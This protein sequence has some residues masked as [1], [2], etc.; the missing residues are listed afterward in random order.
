MSR[1][2]YGLRPVEE[3]LRSKR[4]IAVVYLLEGDRS[5]AL[6]AIAAEARAANLTVMPR[7]RAALD[8]LVGGK[9]HQGAVAVAGDFPYLEPLDVVSRATEKLEVPLLLVLDG[10]QDPQNLGALVR[11]AHVLG[12]HGVIMPKDRAVQ[13]TPAVVKASAGATEHTPIA[14]CANL[15]RTLEELKGAGVWTVG[16]L[17]D[18]GEDPWRLDLTVPIALVLGAEGT[19]LRPL[20]VRGC[21]LL[22]KIPMVGRVASLNVAAAGA[23]LLYEVMR[24][25]APWRKPT[26]PS[27]PA[28]PAAPKREKTQPM[29]PAVP[30]KEP[31]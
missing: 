23:I 10:V 31:T 9:P 14:R 28:V 16:A 4:E 2:V 24:Q 26:R 18:G 29:V 25:R 5:P 3:L 12:A 19:G 30:K 21:D 20:V 7:A 27:L 8:A 22:V 11:S 13:V 6:Q 1:L 15:A 17:A